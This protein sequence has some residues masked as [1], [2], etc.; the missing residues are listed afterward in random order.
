MVGAMIEIS[1]DL[2]A[3]RFAA[4]EEALFEVEAALRWNLTEDVELK[5]YRALGVFDDEASAREAWDELVDVA[6]PLG[7]PELRAIDAADWMD[8]YKEH[9][10]PWAIGPLHWV[11]VWL[12]GEYVLPAG[13]EAVWLDPGMAF[14]TGNHETTRLCVE[15]L[16]AA[17]ERVGLAAARELKVVDAGCGSGILAISARRLGF[18][19]VSGFDNDADAVRIA[20]ENAELNGAPETAFAV[21]DLANGFRDAPYDV[22]LANILAVALIECRERLAA[23]VGAGG[24]L[25]LSGI[26][27]REAGQVRAA[28]ESLRAWQ[29]VEVR[30]MGEWCSVTLLG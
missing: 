5:T 19:A 16:I 8:G 24:T 13:H 4:V 6:G 9:F 29:S 3:E 28:F 10:Q 11:P 25:I 7:E 18:G 2:D 14:G 30:E 12:R 17:R 26:L 21:D 15:Q 27:A 1:V 23:A 22:V 20:V